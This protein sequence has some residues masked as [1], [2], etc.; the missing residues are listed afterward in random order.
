MMGLSLSSSSVS[1]ENIC[2]TSRPLRT[3]HVLL[4]TD[5]L[6]NQLNWGIREDAF[7]VSFL[8][9]SQTRIRR[10]SLQGFAS[11]WM[12]LF[13]NCNSKQ[14]NARKTF[15]QCFASTWMQLLNN[16]NSWLYLF[17]LKWFDWYSFW[18]HDGLIDWIYFY[19]FY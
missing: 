16:C 9:I 14:C 5:D 2:N 19:I 7:Q 17:I 10:T 1:W 15:L 13:N 6:V 8:L 3:H 4:L 12:Q 11:T 18:N